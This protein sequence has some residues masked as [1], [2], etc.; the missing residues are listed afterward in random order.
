MKHGKSE[1]FDVIATE[2]CRRVGLPY[3]PPDG[4]KYEVDAATWA[5]KEEADFE[6]W[7]FDYLKIVPLFKRMGIKYIRKEIQWFMFQFSWKTKGDAA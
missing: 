3:P 5:E 1:H 4:T 6:K 2:L 7:L